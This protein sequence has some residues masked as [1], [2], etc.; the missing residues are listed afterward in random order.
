MLFI[1]SCET[2]FLSHTI[3]LWLDEFPLISLIVQVCQPQI[4]SAFI[5]L[6]MSISHSFLKDISLHIDSSVV[7]F[8]FPSSFSTLKMTIPLS[9]GLHCFW[10]KINHLSYYCSTAH[11]VLIFPS[12]FN[13]F[14][15]YHCLWFSQFDN[16]IST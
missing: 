15:P 2:R 10:L 8:S 5:Y 13:M 9:S 16:D 4:F 6:H 7:G 1:S 14:F 12:T 11:N 3:F